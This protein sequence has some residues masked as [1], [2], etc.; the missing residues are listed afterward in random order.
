MLHTVVT[1]FQIQLWQ[2]LLIYCC[3]IAAILPLASILQLTVQ[4][5]RRGV[6]IIS[7]MHMGFNGLP[8][9]SVISKYRPYREGFYFCEIPWSFAKIKLSRKFPNFWF[10]YS[11]GHNQHR[12]VTIGWAYKLFSQPH[13]L[14]FCC[15]SIYFF[16]VFALSRIIGVGTIFSQPIPID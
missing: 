13:G 14:I 7:N 3:I 16:K 15:I 1:L 5:H 10:W 2:K 9:K 4:T 11:L 8:L 12:Y 6:V